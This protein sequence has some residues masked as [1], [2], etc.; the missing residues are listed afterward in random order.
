MFT[1]VIICIFCYFVQEADNFTGMRVIFLVVNKK[2][3]I[4]SREAN[5]GISG[6]SCGNLSP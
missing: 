4:W 1:T 6:F 5:K 2:Y 3:R